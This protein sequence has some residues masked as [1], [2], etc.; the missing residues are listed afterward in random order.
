MTRADQRS[1]IEPIERTVRSA[2]DVLQVAYQ[3]LPCDPE[4]AD[5]AAFC[6]HYGIP[7]SHSAN[8]IIVA[9]KKEPK[10][11]AACLAL[12][13]TQLDVN[14]AVRDLMGGKKLSF[15]TAQ[16]TQDLTGMMVGGVTPF[17]L[18]EKLPIYIDSRV[19]EAEYV[20][21][22]GG[23]RSCKIKIAP[24][25]LQRLPGARVIENLARERR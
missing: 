2:L 22:G 15:A 13:T 4:L 20:V 18:P 23:S 1:E 12:A 7:P 21:V 10:Q 6:E 3:I 24:E 16:E 17:G 11:Y 14:H 8:A 25:A 5:T 9:S 19:M